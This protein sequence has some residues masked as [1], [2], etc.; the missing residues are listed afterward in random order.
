LVPRT[1]AWGL[2][3]LLGL[4]VAWEGARLHP[5]ES[6]YLNP[7]AVLSAGPRTEQWLEGGH[8]GSALKEGSEWLQINAEPDAVIYAPLFGQLA[9][10]Y[11][12]KRMSVS[13][14]AAEFLD[15]SRPRYLMLVTRRAFYSRAMLRIEASREPIFTIRRQRST[16]LEIYRNDE[17]DS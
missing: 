5:Y 9:R 2:L 13:Y 11:L 4:A 16:L 8:W 15:A 3:G 17:P 1:S 12:G 14:S 7:I 10:L 6:A